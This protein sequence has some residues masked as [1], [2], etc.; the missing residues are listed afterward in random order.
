MTGFGIKDVTKRYVS[1]W[2][3]ETLKL[4]PSNDDDK[5]SFW[6]TCLWLLSNSNQWRTK[7]DEKEDMMLLQTQVN[8]K[9]PSSLAG[10]KNHGL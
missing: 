2:N 6:S 5:E 3:G 8:E 9:F 10:F 7:A 4:R 1:Q